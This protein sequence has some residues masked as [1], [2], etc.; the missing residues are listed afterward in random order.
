MLIATTLLSVLAAAALC[1][2]RY[3]A[4]PLD[5]LEAARG[6][7]SGSTTNAAME[8]IV[9]KVRLPRVAASVLIGCALSL[10]G[11]AYQSTFRNPLVSPDLLGVSSG[12]SLGAAIAL[13]FGMPLS[14]VQLFAF[15]GGIA[16]VLA[17][18]SLPKLLR[19][20][21]NMALVLSGIIVSSFMNAVIGIVKL[22]SR[23]QDQLAA[24]V[25]WQMGSL[26]RINSKQLLSSAPVIV[27]CSAVM[28]A[29]SWRMNILSFGEEEARSVGVN[30]PRLRAIAI[31]CASLLTASSVSISG[32]IGWIGLVIPHFGR[33][34]CGSDNTRLMPLAAALG[35]IF[36]LLIDTAARTATSIEIPISILTGLIGAPMYAWLLFKLRAKIT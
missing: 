21:S 23:E 6:K 26:S 2:G 19:N 13:Y 35:G 27:A 1:F 9:F 11:A 24:I 5:V 29:I 8:T 31:I 32:S 28:I 3:S 16:A 14:S 7:L 10:S 33:L 15:A 4:N 30:V 25:F 34:I 18:A 12:A 36:L 20:P 17:A 22:L